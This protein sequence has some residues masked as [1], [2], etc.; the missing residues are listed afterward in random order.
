[1]YAMARRRHPSARDKRLVVFTVL[2]TGTVDME[3]GIK[4]E[5]VTSDKLQLSFS[6]PVELLNADRIMNALL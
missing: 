1:M 6:W 4:A 3:E 5:L 2:P